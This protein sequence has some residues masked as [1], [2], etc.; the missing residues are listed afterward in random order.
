MY[1]DPK[2]IQKLIQHRSKEHPVISLYINVAPPKR[3]FT[4]LNSLFHS[5]SESIRE[6]KNFSKQN[7]T[8]LDE[9]IGK[10]ESYCQDFKNFENARAFILFASTDGLWEEFRLP[11]KLT[12]QIIVDRSP[13]MRP[14]MAVMD[15]FK[16]HC[17][18]IADG[19]SARVFRLQL[20]DFVEN[21]E[22]FFEDSL[23]DRVS[24]SLSATGDPFTDGYGGLGDE[25][26]KRNIKH[27]IQKH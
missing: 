23:S 1:I 15:E 19:N 25:R 12:S 5:A 7:L 22:L 6:N 3:L 16:N 20:G 24:V 27:R 18:L 11:V 10:I 2:Q 21:K 17:V 14:L 13:F 8:D 26:I 4:E 9:L